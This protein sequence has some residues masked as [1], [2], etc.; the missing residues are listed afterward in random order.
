MN[1]FLTK[2]RLEELKNELEFLKK[3]TRVEIAEKLKRA[4]EYGDLSENAE[5]IDAKEEKEKV[6]SR[7]FELE[8]IIRNASI[9]KKS[10]VKNI[11]TIGSTVEIQ[12]GG[13]AIKYT[14]VGVHESR[15][16]ENIISNESLLGKSFLGKKVGDVVEMNV[17]SGKVFY[18]IIGIE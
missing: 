5:Y 4:K 15:P 7:I 1:Y 3:E 16:E 18:K 8:E 11:V 14:I 10:G 6:E 12:R 13:K 9:I 17:L 2:E